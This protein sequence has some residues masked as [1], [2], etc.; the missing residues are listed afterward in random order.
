[1]PDINSV[2]IVGQAYAAPYAEGGTEVANSGVILNAIEEHRAAELT[3]VVSELTP[4]ADT[5]LVG[6][7]IRAQLEER[8]SVD[9]E[10][11]VARAVS[12]EWNFEFKKTHIISLRPGA[13]TNPGVP[14][15]R[16]SMDGPILV[17]YEEGVLPPAYR[18][19]LLKKITNAERLDLSSITFA[20]YLRT[21]QLIPGTG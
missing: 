19:R 5:A 20:A 2:P 14:E 10:V 7:R 12:D 6:Y 3:V 11:F 17:M 21:Y 1:M 18:I 15:T 16:E 4:N 8:V 9:P 13:V